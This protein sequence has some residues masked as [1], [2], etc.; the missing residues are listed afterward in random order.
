MPVVA[1]NSDSVKALRPHSIK[2]VQADL[3]PTVHAV[4][5][6][7]VFILMRLCACN[8]I[9]AREKIN[10]LFLQRDTLDSSEHSGRLVARHR[11]EIE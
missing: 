9:T 8:A 7:I 2:S 5:H 11:A 3:Q 6:L 1:F 4:T 10:L